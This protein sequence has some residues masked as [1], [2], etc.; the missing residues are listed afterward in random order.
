MN[1]NKLVA[2]MLCA[3]MVVSLTGC[4]SS[5]SVSVKELES[6]E[7]SEQESTVKAVQL[8]TVD[9]ESLI[10]EQVSDR[11]LLDL[12]TLAACD[13]SYV[14]A[15]EQFM[16]TVNDQVTGAVDT[17]NGVISEN[18]V[19]YML[20]EMEKTPY[21]W[22]RTGMVI[23]GMDAN[24][25]NVVVDVTYSTNTG[26]AKPVKMDSFIIRG[27]DNYDTKMQVRNE[28]WNNYLDTKYDSKTGLI[29]DDNSYQA[30]YDEFVRNYG[31]V[32]DIMDAQENTS[33]AEK[34]FETGIVDTYS[35]M[36]DM[37]YEQSTGGE[38]TF[39]YVLSPKYTLGINLGWECTH[40]YL[41]SYKLAADPTEGMTVYTGTDLDTVSDS[42]DD[43]M[44]SYYKAIEEDNHKGLYSLVADYQKYDKYFEDY[45]N[46]TYKKNNNYTIS[47]FSVEGTT[48]TFGVTLSRKVRAK[49]SNMTLPLYT[50]RYLYTA[51]LIGDKLQITNETLLSSTIEG[52]PA[53]TV[54]DA[55]TS[56]FSSS[57]T[58]TTADKQS[59]EKV[60]SEFGVVQLSGKYTSDAFGKVVDT[61][62]ASNVID[63]IETNME[64]GKGDKKV[65]WLNSYLQGTTNYASVLCK[66]LTQLSDGSIL[67]REVTYELLYKG[68][69]WYVSD[70]LVTS[71][72]KL[73]T[74][75]LTTK[76]ALCICTAKEVTDFT[77]QVGD[78]E[79]NPDEIP[80]AEE[81]TTQSS[82]VEMNY[83]FDITAPVVKET[84]EEKQ[85]RLK[86]EKEAAEEA[87]AAE[88]GDAETAAE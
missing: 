1:K 78:S 88:N 59:I 51:Q 73:D 19:N 27:E 37:P 4:G 8:S 15:I 33:L 58:L 2:S 72:N 5:N 80:T 65:V 87:E 36:T 62:L 77:S 68:D 54:E 7:A 66:E 55:D 13:S 82:G 63:E 48:M 61:S 14:T 83:Q 81:G 49:D 86:K 25:R 64:S 79:K 53:I 45:F 67:E 76:N 41:T 23:R 16:N 46:Y 42:L 31:D 85:A 28:R 32:D 50:E 29:S 34:V 12:T 43:L 38:M 40:M 74:T 3:A 52:E 60:I 35:C 6:L 84:E 30:L 56:G 18:L 10:Y 17:E 75:E 21:Y 70:Y 11:S 69:Q 47:L 22:C 24:S 57:I 44:N 20:F 71:T 39:R 26:V 9:K